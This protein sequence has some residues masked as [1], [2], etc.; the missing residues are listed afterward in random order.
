MFSFSLI[1]LPKSKPNQTSSNLLTDPD[2]NISDITIRGVGKVREKV[3]KLSLCASK[4][5]TA[6]STGK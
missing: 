5:N 6:I 4:A 3:D 1:F 2:S